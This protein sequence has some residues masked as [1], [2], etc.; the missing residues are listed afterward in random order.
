M[1]PRLAA[2]PPALTEKAAIP[3]I[4]RA[5]FW[6]D[7]DLGPFIQSAVQ[8]NRRES[9]ALATAG[10]PNA[11]MPPVRL[12]AISGGGDGGAFA[13]GLLGGWTACGTRPVFT[14]VTG[15]SAGALIAPFAFLGS[16]YD[17]VLRKVSTSVA[18]E[19]IFRQHNVLVGLS[20]DGMADSTPLSRIIAKYVTPQVLAEIA[21]EF[22][23]GRAL[24]IETTD[25]DSGRPVTWDMGAIAASGA[26]GSLELFRKIVLASSSVPG[27]VSPVMI[28]V[29]IDGTHYQEMHVDGGVINQVFLYPA[30]S[31]AKM[32]RLAGEPF[33][34]EIQIFV[35]RNGRLEPEWLESKRRTLRI[36]ARAIGML[37]QAQGFSD[38]SRIYLTARQDKADFNLAYIDS[39]FNYPHDAEFDTEYMRRLFDYS[40]ALGSGGYPWHKTPPSV[41]SLPFGDR[42]RVETV[43]DK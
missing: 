39:G 11:P 31:V 16:R 6:L 5:R 25:L 12:L 26:A 4:P 21:G 32:S 13:S 28:D 41:D 37:I 24:L 7:G 42:E 43:T 3:G 8:A 33:R 38:L 1:L 35:I 19:D 36:G 2:V 29:E 27:V 18:V 10:K 9:E 34:R 22:S 23:R 20:R 17:D 14:V 40:Y 15:V 30:T